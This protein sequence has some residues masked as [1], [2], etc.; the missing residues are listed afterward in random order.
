MVE[1]R[2]GVIEERAGLVQPDRVV[3]EILLVPVVH[4]APG[5]SSFWI[6]RISVAAREGAAVFCSETRGTTRSTSVTLST[7]PAVVCWVAKVG[8]EVENT[9]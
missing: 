3:G 2:E 7:N 5:W 8:V 9:S 6:S 1:E 4:G